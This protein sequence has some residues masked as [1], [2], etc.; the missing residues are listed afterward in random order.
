MESYSKVIVLD[1]FANSLLV[2]RHITCRIRVKNVDT[3]RSYSLKSLREDNQV[4]TLYKNSIFLFIYKQRYYLF[5]LWVAI[6]NLQGDYYLLIFLSS[7][8]VSWLVKFFKHSPVAAEINC[9][10]S[11]LTCDDIT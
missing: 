7:K 8:T 5:S 4:Q 6:N 2:L 9:R 11:G 1:K 3:E 10:L